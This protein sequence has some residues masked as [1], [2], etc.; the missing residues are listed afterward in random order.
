MIRA[1][2]VLLTLAVATPAFGA[3]RKH[4]AQEGETTA[5]LAKH[6]YGTAWKAVYLRTHNTLK[7]D[8]LS[9]G[10]VIEL[11]SSYVYKARAG[12]SYASIAK[13][14]MFSAK[15][16]PALL[17]F[18]GL[19]ENSPLSVGKE[20]IL[21]FH[22][23]HFVQEGDSLSK[24]AVQYYRTRKLARTLREY[25]GLESNALDVGQKIV[26]PIF[27][28]SSVTLDE[29]PVPAAPDVAASAEPESSESVPVA[30][31]EPSPAA[32]LEESEP[33]PEVDAPDEPTLKLPTVQATVRAYRSGFF[34]GA[35]R[36]FESFLE[37]GGGGSKKNRRLS[38][39][40]RSRVI[41][42]LAFCAVAAGD[43]RAASDYFRSWL[44]TDPQAT[45]DRRLTSPKILTIFDAVAREVRRSD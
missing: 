39:E 1:A 11:P 19:R 38:N 34:K 5:S 25:N 26:V 20:L 23:F 28:R 14:R 40:D 2:I 31:A 9:A 33:A 36:R 16:Y 29:K 32:D 15:R 17:Q 10:Q 4:T 8:A 22:L 42:Y 30:E 13:R 41:Q 45:L 35:C 12:D 18:N 27:D 24:I 21:P 3:Y 7:S 43:A 44:L 6:Y 37:A